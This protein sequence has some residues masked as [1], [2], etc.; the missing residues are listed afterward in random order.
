MLCF[1]IHFNNFLALDA[2]P[3][4]DGE[5]IGESYPKEDYIGQSSVNKLARTTN[6]SGWFSYFT[7]H[8]FDQAILHPQSF[9]FDAGSWWRPIDRHRILRLLTSYRSDSLLESEIIASESDPTVR[10]R[11]NPKIR[12]VEFS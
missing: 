6:D 7:N 12:P 10:P 11:I 4:R 5:T 9:R 3:R 8:G 2:S 1:G